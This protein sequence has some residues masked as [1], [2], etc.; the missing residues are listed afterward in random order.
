[1]S[2][3]THLQ[4]TN[5]TFGIFG[6]SLLEQFVIGRGL[7]VRMPEQVGENLGESPE[8]Y[9]YQRERLRAAQDAGWLE[10]GQI[11]FLNGIG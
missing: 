2:E 3:R 8:A 5:R 6:K 9:A 10:S 11:D 1:M 4:S 7:T